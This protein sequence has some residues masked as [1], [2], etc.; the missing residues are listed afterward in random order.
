MFS[1]IV[2]SKIYIFSE[3]TRLCIALLHI[4]IIWREWRFIQTIKEQPPPMKQYMSDDKFNLLKKINQTL[5]L[6]ELVNESLVLFLRV[7]FLSELSHV[8]LWNYSTHISGTTNETVVTNV[9]I[10]LSTAKEFLFLLPQSL[11]I[12]MKF[13]GYNLIVCLFIMVVQFIMLQIFQ[14]F[15]FNF[16]LILSSLL[17]IVS[18][19]TMIIC[20]TAFI[21]SLALA[22]EL[23]VNILFEETFPLLED[24]G[25]LA[26]LRPVLN[27]IDFPEDRI[28]VLKMEE[29]DLP[30]AFT[31]GNKF[32][33]N[34]M[35]IV[36]DTMLVKNKHLNDCC[37]RKEVTGIILHEV[38]HVHFNHT[39]KTAFLETFIALSTSIF[40]ILLHQDIVFQSFGFETIRPIIVGIFIR[41]ELLAGYVT[42]CSLA[43]MLQVR[44]FEFAADAFSVKYSKVHFRHALIKLHLVKPRDLQTHDQWF[45]LWNLTHPSLMERLDRL[46]NTEHQH[47]EQNT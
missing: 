4:Y 24:Q 47:H 17:S 20:V 37:S 15:F 14:L 35:V 40:F 13:K 28:F 34:Q 10:F 26:E 12:L 3:L 11:Y 16:I 29:E 25:I 32:M 30:N 45:S 21:L 36:A 1:L 41:M 33:N 27:E 6:I 39:L 9:F 2:T 46:D 44:S 42:I 43:Y 5:L 23:L 19:K 7:M 22:R 18:A 38:G 8:S 31:V